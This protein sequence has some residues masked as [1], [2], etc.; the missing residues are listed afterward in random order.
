M[1]RIA[2]A[3][4]SIGIG[5]VIFDA[6]SEDPSHEAFI[7][8]RTSSS[9][10][11]VIAVDYSD[12]EKIQDA[13]ETHQISCVISALSMKDDE[14]GQAQINLIDAAARCSHTKRFMPSEFGAKYTEQY[15]VY[16]Y[17]NLM[18]LPLLT[19]YL[20]RFGT[21]LRMVGSS[22]LSIA[23]MKQASS[24]PS[25]PTRCSWII[26]SH[27][28]SSQP[29]RSIFRPGLIWTTTS[30]LFLVTVIHR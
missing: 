27:R 11:R 30:L 14:A 13:L 5:R 6:V 4:G 15:V 10:S 20:G 3:G 9:D 28:V 21:Y 29:S 25:S 16:T 17:V 7:L 24:T 2:V 26:G 18:G 22:K 19:Y 12:V 1:V 23:S 8:S